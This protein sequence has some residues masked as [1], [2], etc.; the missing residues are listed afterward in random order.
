MVNLLV[1]L[2]STELLLLELWSLWV[3]RS[4][5]GPLSVLSLLFFI[6]ILS[7]SHTPWCSG[8]TLGWVGGTI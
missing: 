6:F 8:I 2:N 1:V 7:L 3:L 4:E 5:L